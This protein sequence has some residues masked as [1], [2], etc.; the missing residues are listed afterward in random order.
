[1]LIALLL[2][3]VRVVLIVSNPNAAVKLYAG[4]T[5]ESRADARMLRIAEKLSG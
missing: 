5:E 2:F 4:T 1:M 3:L